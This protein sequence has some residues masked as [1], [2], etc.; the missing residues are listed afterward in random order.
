MIEMWTTIAI[1]S[2]VGGIVCVG[3]LAW[4]EYQDRKDEREGQ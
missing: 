2:L 3:G 4:C 1:M